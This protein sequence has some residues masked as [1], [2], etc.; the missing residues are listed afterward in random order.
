MQLSQL[1]PV[2]KRYLI[3]AGIHANSMKREETQL[4]FMKIYILC[5]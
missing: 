5:F 2:F 4:Q 1:V 3:L